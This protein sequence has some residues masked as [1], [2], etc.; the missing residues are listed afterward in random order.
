M[1]R[2]IKWKLETLGT[3]MPPEQLDA[4]KKE[5]SLVESGFMAIK[6]GYMPPEE[7]FLGLGP[8]FWKEWIASSTMTGQNLQQ[9]GKPVLYI[10]GGFDQ[11]ATAQDHQSFKDALGVAPNVSAG[12]HF[13]LNVARQR[14]ACEQLA[15]DMHSSNQRVSVL[16]SVQEIRRN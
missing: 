7:R 1:V 2:R 4:L 5:L 3:T 14:L 12:R 9:L 15:R 16:A 6:E 13:P 11:D 8:V 10:R